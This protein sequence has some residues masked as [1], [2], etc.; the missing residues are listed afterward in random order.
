MSLKRRGFLQ[1][2]GGAVAAPLMPAVSLGSTTATASAAATAYPASAFHAAIYHAQTRVSV[3][4]FGLA[5]TLGLK[6]VQAEVLMADMSARG[7]LGPL[8]GTVQRGGWANSNV[9][10]RH[11]GVAAA[12]RKLARTKPAKAH[13]VQPNATSAGADM[14]PFLTHLYDICRAQ[15]RMLHPRCA[16]LLKGAA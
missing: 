9:L 11:K 13:V 7:I 3:S 16:D 15:G 6:T 1:M 5:H 12:A 4:V 14:R 8:Q 10:H 2:L